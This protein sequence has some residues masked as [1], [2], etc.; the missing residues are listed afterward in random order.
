MS[1][2][3]NTDA[4]KKKIGTTFGEELKAAGLGGLP[5]SWTEDGDFWFAETLTE[6]QIESI[7]A[8]YAV[9]VPDIE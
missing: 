6:E 9:H 5:F 4:V 1:D 3:K 8:V 2:Q 7:Q